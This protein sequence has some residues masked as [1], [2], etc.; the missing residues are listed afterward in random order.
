VMI[1]SSVPQKGWVIMKY[2][3]VQISILGKCDDEDAKGKDLT[4]V[5]FG[6]GRICGVFNT[7]EVYTSWLD[8]LQEAFRKV[9]ARG[10]QIFAEQ[11]DLKVTVKLLRKM[12]ADHLLNGLQETT[13]PTPLPDAQEDK[14]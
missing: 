7:A 14:C 2:L 1:K 3:P 11:Q 6:P 8:A 13:T 9:N 4:K 12:D 5:D 10:H